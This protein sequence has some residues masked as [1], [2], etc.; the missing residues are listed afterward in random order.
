MNESAESSVYCTLTAPFT[1]ERSHA[2]CWG[3][4][5]GAQGFRLAAQPF[6]LGL[7]GPESQLPTPDPAQVRPPER[8]ASPRPACSPCVGPVSLGCLVRG[9]LP[10]SIRLG[11]HRSLCAS[12]HSLRPPSAALQALLSQSSLP[13]KGLGRP[14]CVRALGLLSLAGGFPQHSLPSGLVISLSSLST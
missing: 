3:S 11:V 4:R 12:P 7:H 2:K 8:C 5:M 9:L 6:R 14:S 1:S 10:L 13:E